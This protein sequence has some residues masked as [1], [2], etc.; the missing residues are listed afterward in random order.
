MQP[1]QNNVLLRPS[2]L[3]ASL[4]IV[5][6]PMYTFKVLLGGCGDLL[7]LLSPSTYLSSLAYEPC[8][9]LIWGR[10]PVSSVSHCLSLQTNGICGNR[11]CYQF[12]MFFFHNE[13]MSNQGKMK[14]VGE[15][16][17]ALVKVNFFSYKSMFKAKYFIIIKY[18]LSTKI[19]VTSHQILGIWVDIKI[20]LYKNHMR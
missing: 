6:I 14:F 5:M 7:V 20:S 12:F 3:D 11:I 4:E 19:A 15:K 8:H 9:L 17:F 16:N 10:L 2:G 1:W 18:K 13:L